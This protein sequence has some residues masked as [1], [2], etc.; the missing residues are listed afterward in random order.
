M[1]HKSIQYVARAVHLSFRQPCNSR[2]LSSKRTSRPIMHATTKS[3]DGKSLA[4][5][6]R[7]LLD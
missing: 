1:I 3:A 7:I 5:R 4:Y 6:Q 2:V